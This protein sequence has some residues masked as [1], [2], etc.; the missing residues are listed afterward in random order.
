VP[1]T[2]LV[3]QSLEWLLKAFERAGIQPSLGS[4]LWGTLLEAGLR[5]LGMI[6]IQ[7]HFGPQ[8]PDGPAIL[9]GIVRAVL[10]L[11][12][13]TGVATA[14]EVGIETF[15]R[16]LTDELVGNGAVFAHPILLSAWGTA[17][18][19]EGRRHGSSL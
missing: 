13:R 4:R 16:R 5:P 2:P 15:Q 11:M 10:P 9:A 19:P 8:D 7:P 3:G 6:G 12:E 17:G 1:P 18:E 14:Q